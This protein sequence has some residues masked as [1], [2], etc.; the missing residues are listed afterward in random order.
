MIYLKNNCW[1][2]AIYTASE[3]QL[4]PTISHKLSLVNEQTL[5][6]TEDITIENVSLNTL[7]YDSAWIASTQMQTGLVYSDDVT[8]EAGECIVAY[9]DVEIETGNIL[10]INGT[11]III[12]G[13]LIGDYFLVGSPSGTLYEDV[14]E[15]D[16][17]NHTLTVGDENKIVFIDM[18]SGYYRYTITDPL[19]DMV[20]EIGKLLIQPNTIA[21]VKYEPSVTTIVYNPNA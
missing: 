14:P 2:E 4:Q 7:R 20:L 3:N 6:K 13:E 21:N 16:I 15:T 11:L 19:N 8:I 12:E 1:T 5:N 9:G 17:I 18:Q 10:Y